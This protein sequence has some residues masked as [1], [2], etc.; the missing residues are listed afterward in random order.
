MRSWLAGFLTFGLVYTLFIVAMF[1]FDWPTLKQPH[2]YSTM[3]SQLPES[4]Q[5]AILKVLV[6]SEQLP[7]VDGEATYR[8]SPRSFQLKDDTVADAIVFVNGNVIVLEENTPAESAIEIAQAYEILLESQV[9]K[10]A[11]HFT[12]RLILLL[13]VPL[14]LFAMFA[15][16]SRW[17]WNKVLQLH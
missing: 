1:A 11:R 14:T 2:L 7:G 13:L 17:L 12:S 16:F 3:E 9:E 8:I 6:K 4:V 10:V 15:F 5:G